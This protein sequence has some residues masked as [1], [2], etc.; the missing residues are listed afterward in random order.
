MTDGRLR[1][2][3]IFHIHKYEAVDIDDVITEMA[4]LKGRRPAISCKAL[5][6]TTVYPILF[7]SLPKTLWNSR[8]LNFQS[9]FIYKDVQRSFIADTIVPARASGTL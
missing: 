4:R 2:L 3:A 7:F 9:H 6:F 1:S 8:L 5:V